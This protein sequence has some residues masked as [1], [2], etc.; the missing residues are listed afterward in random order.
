MI[1]KEINERLLPIIKK[2]YEPCEC[3][4]D[5]F[6]KSTT[7][8]WDNPLSYQRRHEFDCLDCGEESYSEWVKYVILTGISHM[9]DSL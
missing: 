4:Y 7:L 1:G 6:Y 5:Y 3:G 8:N 9:V 2:T